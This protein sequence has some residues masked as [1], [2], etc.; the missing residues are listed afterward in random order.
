MAKSND[1][2]C[3]VDPLDS[4]NGDEDGI[5]DDSPPPP[6]DY[7]IPERMT[8]AEHA[9]ATINKGHIKHKDP[10][11][12]QVPESK[13]GQDNNKDQD[14]NK[15]QMAN[16]TNSNSRTSRDKWLARGKIALQFLFNYIKIFCIFTGILSIYWA[17]FYRR[18]DR[19]IHF[20]M[21]LITQDEEFTNIN[22]T[23][24]PPY[25]SNAFIDMITQ[26]PQVTELGT[27]DIIPISN[28]TIQ[29]QN[30]NNTVEEEVIRV[31][32][33]QKYWAGVYISPNSTE[34]I[35]NMMIS[36]NYSQVLKVPYLINV[37]Y[38]SGRHYSALS[39]YVTRNLALIEDSWIVNHTSP[40]VY[41]PLINQYLSINQKENLLT[42]N[43]TL[44]IL[45]MKPNFNLMDQR[46]APSAAVLGPSELGLIYAQ[47][48]SFHQFN[49]S[50]E[51]YAYIRTRLKY[52]QYI[53]YRFIAAQINCLVLSL[54]YALITIAFQVPVNIAFGHSG[55]M[56]LW[57]IMFLFIS[58]SG[59][60]NE[61]VV[62]L[63]LAF[64]KKVLLAPWMIFNIVINIS[65][66][67]APFVMMPGFFHY[68]YGLPMY[69]TY[70]ALKIVFF[71]T[72][73]GH[74]GRNLGVLVIWII[75]TNILLIFNVRWCDRRAKRLA[76]EE[77]KKKEADATA[78]STSPIGSQDVKNSSSSSDTTQ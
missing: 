27:W 57:M 47:V 15:D 55:F 4:N 60:I 31:I 44:S 64:D 3:N 5:Y 20:N 9:A 54:V 13:Q 2:E 12:Q 14:Q 71:N 42:N 36:A 43:N 41:E 68:G 34:L 75:L 6:L 63:I 65:T 52:K 40:K 22:G 30:H 56:V 33:H 53:I 24:I 7:S 46:P 11:D 61:N 32:H 74:L 45:A 62:S 50:L 25:L 39:Q 8:G 66:T 38:E 49:F 67:F 18:Q 72:W 37:I 51:I 16:D 76:A 17:T 29:A 28:F 35:Y 73:K 1:K 48:F 70:E 19:Y 23:I 69:N 26:D 58:A 21:L 59:G 77:K 78:S 10:Q